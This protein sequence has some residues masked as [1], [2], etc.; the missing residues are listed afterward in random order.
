MARDWKA[1]V[2]DKEG[3][4]FNEKAYTHDVYIFSKGQRERVFS[5]RELP[6]QVYDWI[7]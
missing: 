5:K 7:D 6:N 2:Q 3:Q 4:D 1:M